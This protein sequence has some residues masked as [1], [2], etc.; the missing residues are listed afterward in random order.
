MLFVCQSQ[1]ARSI[2]LVPEDSVEADPVDV[3]DSRVEFATKV[4]N[5]IF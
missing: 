1:V 2:L 4:D 5:P 3:A